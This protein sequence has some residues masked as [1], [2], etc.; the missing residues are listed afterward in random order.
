MQ[1]TDIP[2]RPQLTAADYL[3]VVIGPVLIIAMVGSLTQFLADV[4]YG[5]EFKGAVRWTLFWFTLACVLVS[6]IS[7]EHGPWTARAYGLALGA[8]TGVRLVFLIGFQIVPLALVGLVWW[9]ASRIT[10]DCALLDEDEDATGEGLLQRAGAASSPASLPESREGEGETM[11]E[12]EDGNEKR[13]RAPGLWVVWFSLGALPVFGLGQLAI[14]IADEARRFGAWV[15]L[16]VYLASALGLLLVTSFL[17]LRRY[18]R[19]RFLVMPP[20]MARSW[21]TSGAAVAVAALGLALLL[22]RPQGP[23]TLVALGERIRARPQQASDHATLGGDAARGE[24]RQSADGAD[25]EAARNGEGRG[26]NG[27]GGASGEGRG[28]GADEG[29]GESGRASDR[30]EGERPSRTGESRARSSAPPVRARE[31][32]AGWVKALMGLAG[33]AAVVFVLFRFGGEWLQALKARRR[34]SGISRKA[35]ETVANPERP[36]SDYPN[37]F[38]TGLARRMSPSD[39]T[40]YTFNALQAWARERGKARRPDQTPGE[41]GEALAR[42]LAHMSDEVYGTV[43][44]YARVAYAGLEVGPEGVAVLER[45]WAGLPINRPSSSPGASRRR[46]M[47]L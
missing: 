31:V 7:I 21:L 12:R 20:A 4:G 33:I 40:T 10:W 42:E 28:G 45:L 15:L 32:D 35:Q 46:A 39:L 16:C 34:R 13:P 47:F 17:G 26:L 6:R 9:C 27:E 14:P 8:A 2:Q 30:A 22:P 38:L 18:L 24:G 37:P 29:G 41:F 1:R 36:F 44:L 11:A 3:G 25:A 5:G 43:R 23:E 19:Q